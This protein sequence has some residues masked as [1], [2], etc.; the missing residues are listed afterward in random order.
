MNENR[1]MVPEILLMVVLSV[2]PAKAQK[3]PPT[4]R[5]QSIKLEATI[6]GNQEQ[7]KVLTIVPWQSPKEKQALPSLILQ[8]L[9]NKFQPLERDE[10]QRK[11]E[12]FNSY[13]NKDVS[14]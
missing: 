4:L 6:R 2:F 11:I 12:F 1:K 13:E 3:S 7:P 10:F 5:Q 8:R 14:P 9:N